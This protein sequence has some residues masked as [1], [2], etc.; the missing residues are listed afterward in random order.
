MARFA[1]GYTKVDLGQYREAHE[2][3]RHYSSLVPGNAW[4]WCHLG[5]ACQALED[6]EGAEYAYRQAIE[7]EQKGSF[8]TDAA[9]LLGGLLEAK[10]RHT[11]GRE[12][13]RPR[14]LDTCEDEDG[15]GHG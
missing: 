8:E 7:A 4:A 15:G 10:A 14:F 12:A 2:N 5:I 11:T 9:E 13:L 6:F 1:I 3:L